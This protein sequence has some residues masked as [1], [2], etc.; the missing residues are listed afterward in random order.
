VSEHKPHQPAS[1]RINSENVEHSSLLL[2]RTKAHTGPA[3]R[4]D[5]RAEMGLLRYDGMLRALVVLWLSAPAALPGQQASIG[6]WASTRGFRPIPPAVVKLARYDAS[7]AHELE[8]SLEEARTATP[9]AASAFERIDRLLAAHPEL[10]QAAWLRAERYALEAQ[11]RLRDG[12]VDSG[13]RSEDL[14]VSARA[15][16]G[17]RAPSFGAASAKARLSP[18]GGESGGLS[19]VNLRSSDQVIIDGVATTQGAFIDPGEHHVQVLRASAL[20]WAGWVQLGSPPQLHI[21]DPTLPC[22]DLDLLGVE[23]RPDAP[24]PP[25]GVACPTWAVARPG[26]GGSVDLAFCQGSHCAAWEH[27][28]GRNAPLTLAPANRSHTVGDVGE[29]L[30]AWV[31]WSALATGAAVATGLIL[32]QTGAFDTPAPATE[33]VFTGPTA[34]ALQ[35]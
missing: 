9:G 21:L 16:E 25:P 23:A 13:A 17:A 8:R 26:S 10:P 2:R 32:W 6:E 18:N 34:G 11:Y 4:L 7:V 29:S 5:L 22:S 1:R 3:S 20:I 27:V 12:N 24:G 28:G 19:L 35:F 30:P 31:G 15:L 33:F 14:A